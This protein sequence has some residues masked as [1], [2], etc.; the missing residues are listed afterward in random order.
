MLRSEP[1]VLESDLFLGMISYLNGSGST[2]EIANGIY[3]I[4]HFGG[5]HFLPGYER[6]PE[7]SVEPYGVCDSYEQIIEACPELSAEGRAFVIT[8]TPVYRNNQ[9]KSGGWRWHKWGTYI[10]KH[11]PTAEYLHDEPEIEKIYCYHIYEAST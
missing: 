3:E 1:R 10:G 6:Y 9:P 4:G 2:K 11:T 5:S 8:L 7:L